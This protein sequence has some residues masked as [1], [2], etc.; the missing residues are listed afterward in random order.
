M[1]DRATHVTDQN[2]RHRISELA[3]RRQ[4]RRL[5]GPQPNLAHI[6][7]PSLSSAHITRLLIVQDTSSC[8]REI[9]A[10]P[11]TMTAPKPSLALPRRA[12]LRGRANVAEE[13]D[14]AICCPAAA[15]QV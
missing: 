15:G 13:I 1:A 14:G 9:A 12:E 7:T 5:S 4:N 3:V 10:T 11:H 2:F 6:V 8:A